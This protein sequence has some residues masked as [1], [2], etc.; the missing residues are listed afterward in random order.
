MLLCW[1]VHARAVG[2]RCGRDFE[3]HQVLAAMAMKALDPASF[4]GGATGCIRLERRQ[5]DAAGWA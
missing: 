5:R 4:R 1:L 3:Q 2:F